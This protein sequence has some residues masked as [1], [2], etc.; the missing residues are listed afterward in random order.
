MTGKIHNLRLV[1][2]LEILALSSQENVN[3]VRQAF[4][5]LPDQQ[6]LIVV[7]EYLDG[8]ETPEIARRMNLSVQ[9]VQ[10]KRQE[11][12]SYLWQAA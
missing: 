5:R 7:H 12:L 2:F 9:E 3:Q 8:L 4:H 1:Q 11:A 6:Q 10:Y